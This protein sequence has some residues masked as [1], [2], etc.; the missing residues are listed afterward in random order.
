MFYISAAPKALYLPQT[1]RVY[2]VNSHLDHDICMTLLASAGIYLVLDVNSALPNFHLN[3]YEPWTTYNEEYLK[4]VFEVV[5]Q[6]S[7]YNNTLAFFAGNEIVND[8]LS[9]RNSPVYIKAMVRDIKHYMKNN[10]H[11]QIPVGYSA[12]DDLSYR[13]SLSKYL[14][15][16]DNDPAEAVDFYGVNSYQWCG[17][18][19]FYTSGYD[20]LVQS[21][22]DY[23][24]PVFLSE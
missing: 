21:Y 16:I 1:I 4:N 17:R 14:E 22:I 3:R 23:S 11:R 8:R 7:G 5:D 2:S 24:R 18:Q 13:V 19:S 12:A 6:F 20:V 15:C 9:S 10:L